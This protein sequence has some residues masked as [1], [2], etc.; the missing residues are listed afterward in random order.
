MKLLAVTMEY[1]PGM[2]EL[3]AALG[4]GENGFGGTPVGSNPTKLDDWLSYCVRIAQAPPLSEYF[5]PQTNY[6]ITDDNGFVVG[7]LRMYD[8]INQELLNKG[9]HVGY[10]VAPAYRQR[11]FAKGAL[12]LAL[13]NLRSNGVERALLTV[14]SHN[15]ASLALVLAFGGVLEDER[16]DRETGLAYQR[17][18]VETDF[19]TKANQQATE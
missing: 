12:G 4:D 16:I 18:W 15:L 10:Y 9:G 13:A 7:L 14:E 2:A 19:C 11:G 1:Q 6:W 3:L 8:E 17:L 5:L